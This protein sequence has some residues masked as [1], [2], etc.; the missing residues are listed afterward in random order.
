MVEEVRKFSKL[1]GKRGGCAR[2]REHAMKDGSGKTKILVN[3]QVDGVIQA[4]LTG[5]NAQFALET[6]ARTGRCDKCSQVG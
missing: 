4:I 3:I 6:R 1:T 5:A 2:F